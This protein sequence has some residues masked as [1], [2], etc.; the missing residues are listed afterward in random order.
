MKTPDRLQFWLSHLIEIP[1]ISTSSTHNAELKVVLHR[2]RYK[3]LTEGAIYS[4]GDLYTN[5]RITFSRLKWEEMSIQSCLILGLGLGS[6]PDML[7]TRFKKDLQ[8]TA[9]E[10]DDVVT[11]LAYEYVLRPKHIPVDVFSADAASFLQWHE[12]TYDLICSDVFVGDKIP[13]S[14][15][16]P[17]AL[18]EMKGLLSPE[19]LLLYNRLSRYKPDKDQNVRFLEEVFLKVFPEGGYLDVEGNW[20]FVSRKASFR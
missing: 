18:Q 9:V 17:E 7:V 3:L 12:G 4:Y 5:F 10:I 19:G 20:M 8:Y 11:K 14:L 16:T 6:I 2:G 15:Q 13:E 1:V